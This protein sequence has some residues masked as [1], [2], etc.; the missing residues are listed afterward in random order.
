MN[1][2]RWLIAVAL[3]IIT[4]CMVYLTTQGISLRLATLIKPSQ[5]KSAEEVSAALFMRLFPEINEQLEVVIHGESLNE[6]TQKV[7]A[8]FTEKVHE[9]HKA[10]ENR[11]AIQLYVIEFSGR[12]F[13]V[14]EKC[15]KM[16]RLNQ[17]C[18][19]ELG[20]K[21]AERKMK[22]PNMKYFFLKKY[23]HSDYY[24]FVEKN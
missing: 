3:F 24:L 22:N 9:H 20:L 23:N 11:G 16:Q 7:V 2:A 1:K 10:G 15:L 17:A 8:Q 19:R 12:S 5:I 18:I 13:N 6:F 21:S 14:S 4:A